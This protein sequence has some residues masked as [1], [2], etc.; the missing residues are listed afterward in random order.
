MYLKTT[1]WLKA[2]LPADAVVLCMQTSGAVYYDTDFTILRWDQIDRGSLATVLAPL[3]S[4]RRPLYAALY[5]F[6]VEPALK[7]RFPGRWTQV[8][9]VG[10]STIWRREPE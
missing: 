4:T 3:R 8:G 9:K 1:G 6:E 2:N 10:F 7:E 5:P